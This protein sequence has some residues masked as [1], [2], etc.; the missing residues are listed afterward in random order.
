MFTTEPYPCVCNY[1][2]IVLI[3]GQEGSIATGILL[4][5]NT[6]LSPLPVGSKIRLRFFVH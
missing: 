1:N 3:F 2:A 5:P 6:P 4:T